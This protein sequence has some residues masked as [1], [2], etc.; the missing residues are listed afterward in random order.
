QQ[1]NSPAPLQRHGELNY[2]QPSQYSQAGALGPSNTNAPNI[3]HTDVPMSSLP[4]QVNTMEAHGSQPLS[5]DDFFARIEGAKERIGQLNSDIQA[6]ASIHQRMLSSPDNCSSAELEA[7]V[8]RMQ[9]RNTQ[10][11][12]EIKF[13]ERDTMRDPNNRTKR[14]QIEMIKRIF[15]SQLEDLQKEDADYSKRYREAIGRQYRIINPDAT[16]AKV[17]EVANSDLG[18]EG[19]FTQALKYNRSGQAASVLGAVHAR[20]NDIQRIEK[21]MSELALLFTQLNEQTTY[22][23]LLIAEAEVQTVQVEGDSKEAN[24]Q[25]G[26]AIKSAKR[27]RRRKWCIL[28]TIFTILCV[29]ALILGLYF[30]LKPK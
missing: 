20:H 14:S 5:R 16:D 21:T 2:S 22:Q 6:I 3:S 27:A 15:K 11:K 4:T 8:T 26:K 19:I 17:E 30:K 10:I 25:L 13:L 7:I 18:D 23:D 29:I 12:D 1:L 28:L 24:R 9:I